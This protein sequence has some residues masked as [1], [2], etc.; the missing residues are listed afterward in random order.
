LGC[1]RPIPHHAR[2]GTLT[3]MILLGSGLITI[4]V[5]GLIIYVVTHRKKA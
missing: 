2:T 5:V 1:G 3:G 4:G